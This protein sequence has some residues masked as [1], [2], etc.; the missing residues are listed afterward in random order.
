MSLSSI[1]VALKG[2]I[3]AHQ[4]LNEIA[5][6]KT[7]VLKN[8]DMQALNEIVQK[9][10]VLIKELRKIEVNRF[11]LMAQFCQQKGLAT[12]DV[13]L[14]SLLSFAT[15]EEQT[16]LRDLQRSLKEEVHRLKS[17]NELNQILIQDSLRFVNLSLDLLLPDQES[18]HYQHPTQKS[19]KSSQNYTLFDSKA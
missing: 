10:A 3:Q 7:E 16:V 1:C 12:E 18:I 13:T 11:K 5:A 4:S 2:L 8:G 9:E 15:N 19:Q 14:E 6:E 17:Q